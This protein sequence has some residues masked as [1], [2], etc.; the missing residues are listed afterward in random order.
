M[1]YFA[2]IVFVVSLLF[3]CQ[4]SV[5]TAFMITNK[6]DL[7]IDSIKITAFQHPQNSNYI[8]LEPGQ[9]QSYLLDM[10]ALP[11]TD[12]SY[13]ILYKDAIH[14]KLQFGYYTNG[15]PLEKVTNIIIERDTVI[16][17]PIFDTY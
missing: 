16:V 17:D 7:T 3:A 4:S 2:F 6:T 5:S 1:K 12:G 11:K 15:V 9:S 10:T 13:L 14:K 8:K